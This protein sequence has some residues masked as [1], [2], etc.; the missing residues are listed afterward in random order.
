MEPREKLLKKA[1]VTIGPR[2]GIIKMNNVSSKY[3]YLNWFAGIPSWEKTYAEA[4]QRVHGTPYNIFP[5]IDYIYKVQYEWVYIQTS[6]YTPI[7]GN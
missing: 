2:E 1:E 4:W 6:P 5:Q 3:V 7:T